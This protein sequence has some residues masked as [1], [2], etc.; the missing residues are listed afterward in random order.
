MRNEGGLILKKETNLQD[1][2]AGHLENCST[3]FRVWNALFWLEVFCLLFW[4]LVV[5]SKHGIA[6]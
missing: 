1:R 3:F 6:V 2:T 4:R 5:M